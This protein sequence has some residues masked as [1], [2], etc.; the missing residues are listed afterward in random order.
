MT[1]NGYAKRVVLSSIEP[2]K[3]Y[4]KGVTLSD[5]AKNGA[6]V[7]VDTV[8]MPY[9]FA[10]ALVDGECVPVNTE[11]VPISD[12]TKKASTC[13]KRR[14]EI[15]AVRLIWWLSAV[16]GTTWKSE[17]FGLYKSNGKTSQSKDREAEKIG[18]YK[19]K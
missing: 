18:D 9:D 11:D 7:F 17:Y 6:I 5:P 13:S 3:R 2:M 1:D 8:T 15:W 19:L 10:V 14:A 4:R 12:R 16:T